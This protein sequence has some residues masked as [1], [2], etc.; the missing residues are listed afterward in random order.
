MNILLLGPQGSGKGTQARMLAEKY[1]LSYFEA[2]GFLRE[3]GKTKRPDIG[4]R[5]GRGEFLSGKEMFEIVSEYLKE[6]KLFDGIIFDGYPRSL[7]QYNSIKPWFD[8]QGIKIDLAIVLEIDEKETIRRLSARRQDPKTGKIYNLLTDQPGSEIDQSTLVQRK[9]DTPEAIKKR[10]DWHR[11][12]TVPLI[13]MLKREGN[14]VE[15]D[16]SRS[17]ESIQQ[18][19]VKAIEERVKNV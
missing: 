16:G 3:L 17:I 5:I 8:E 6:K 4:E 12:N 14:L 2:G 1:G 15:I 19:I 7:D 9:D 13:E 10:L 11:E 18:D